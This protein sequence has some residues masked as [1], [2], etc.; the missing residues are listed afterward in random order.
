ML[1]P[2]TERRKI[3][4]E[5]RCWNGDA[6]RSRECR[7]RAPSL[8]SGGGRRKRKDRRPAPLDLL[9]RIATGRE[10]PYEVHRRCMENVEEERA[11]SRLSAIFAAAALPCYI[12]TPPWLSPAVDGRRELLA[13]GPH[14]A[15]WTAELTTGEE[16]SGHWR[17]PLHAASGFCF[18]IGRGRSRER[19]M[20]KTKRKVLWLPTTHTC[21]LSI[22]YFG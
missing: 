18:D 7:P 5:L 1:P 11:P 8:P 10:R 15:C 13:G 21:A 16:G 6:A 12:K 4:G 19:K 2:S 20:R 17:P 14:A 3:G 9:L 22:T